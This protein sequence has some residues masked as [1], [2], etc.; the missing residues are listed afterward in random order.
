MKRHTCWP[1]KTRQL[2]ILTTDCKYS[3]EKNAEKGSNFFLVS[4]F[5]IKQDAS[6]LDSRA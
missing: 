5:S 1:Q 6:A 2:T 4:E 3:W